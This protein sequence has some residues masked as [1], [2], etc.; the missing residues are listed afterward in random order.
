MCFVKNTSNAIGRGQNLCQWECKVSI[1]SSN[2]KYTRQNFPEQA[3]TL[4][5]PQSRFG[6]K[7]VKYQVFCPQLSPKR[8]WSPKRVNIYARFLKQKVPN[9][10]KTPKK[11]NSGAD[12]GKTSASEKLRRMFWFEAARIR[13]LDRHRSTKPTTAS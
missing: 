13:A 10:W 12:V 7:P 5:E 9:F 3:L 11:N 2:S 8:D 6:D 4:L 1:Q